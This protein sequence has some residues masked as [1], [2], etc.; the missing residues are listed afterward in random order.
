MSTI[1]YS[2]LNVSATLDGRRVIGLFDGD[3]AIEVEPGADV[4][5]ML[6]GA[7]GS[8]LFSQSAD[9]SAKITLRVKHNSP[10]HRQLL[11]KWRAQRAGL[12]R[13]FTFDVIDSLSNEGGVASD[14]F[15]R[16]APTE[17]KGTNATVREWGLVA[18]TWEPNITNQ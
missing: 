3:N 6:I 9:K 16:T 8:P 2:M 1:A 17:Q 12:I 11:E 5:Q 7:D 15:I 10:T 18:G 14:V 4:G 13:G